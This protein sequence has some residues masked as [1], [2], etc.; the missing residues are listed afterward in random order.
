MPTNILIIDDDTAITELMTMLLKT[1]GFEVK[2]ANSA[3]EGIQSV[4]DH[5]PSVVILDLMMPEKDGWAFCKSVRTFSSVPILV[6]SAI[7]DP[8]K[9]ASILDEGADDYLVKPVP[10][11]VLV[12]HLRKLVRRTGG[13]ITDPLK[14]PP[15]SSPGTQPLSSL[16]S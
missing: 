14:N 6:L 2:T 10:S 7:N 15:S 9:I 4:Q 8:R 3:D 5:A 13:L 1:H 11:N 12:A 16:P